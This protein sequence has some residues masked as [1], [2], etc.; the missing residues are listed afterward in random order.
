ML[1]SKTPFSN[2]PPGGARQETERNGNYSNQ[3]Q[4]D[5]KCLNHEES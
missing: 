5:L 1:Y 4:V 3:D 2:P